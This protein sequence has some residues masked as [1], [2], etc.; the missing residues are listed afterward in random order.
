MDEVWT[1]L[2]NAGGELP[3]AQLAGLQAGVT[4]GVELCVFG[5]EG[6]CVRLQV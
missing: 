1:R 5:N 2:K 4:L 6:G 3:A